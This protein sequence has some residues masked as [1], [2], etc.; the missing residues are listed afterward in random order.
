MGTWSA[1]SFGNDAALD[2]V[3]G[4]S[5]FSALKRHLHEAAEDRGEMDADCASAALAACDLLAAS[6]GRPAEDMPDM[7]DLKGTPA[8]KEVPRDLL[9]L[10]RSLVT[11]IR[12]SSELA[13]LW[14]EDSDEWHEALDD[15][16]A[17]LTP[18]KAYRTSPKPAPTELPDDFIGYCYICYGQVTE[19][20]GLRFEHTMHGATCA[21]YPHRKCIEDQIPGP[22]WAAD[23]APLPGTR[24][25]LLRDMGVE[26]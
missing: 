9:R 7:P 23:G 8:A 2:F 5:S 26:D 12:T 6:I 15:L 11:R 25:K 22:H 4:L 13:E 10:A 21:F 3:S 17:R 24:A 19:Q 18:S 20:N 14:E 16:K 1:G